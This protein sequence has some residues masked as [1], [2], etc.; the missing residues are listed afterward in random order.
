MAV[1]QLDFRLLSGQKVYFDPTY[2]QSV[3]GE[4][5]VNA[6]YIISSIRQQIT[7]AGCFLQDT[8][9]NAEIVIEARVGA[10]GTDGHEIIYGVPQTNSLNSASQVISSIPAIPVLPELALSKIDTSSGVAKIFV[11]A[12]D[13]DTR[14]PIWQSGV[15]KSEST[16]RNT[17]ILG[18]GPIP[19]RDHL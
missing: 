5:F 2:L 11:F 13:K 12:Y 9:E 15:A 8:R 18:A 7:A 16:S 3:K 17:W 4:G 10:L 19:T 6:A 1:A 14:E